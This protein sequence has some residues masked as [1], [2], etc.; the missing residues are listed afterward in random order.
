MNGMSRLE[1]S[2]N[3]TWWNGKTSYDPSDLDHV[4]AAKHLEF[5]PQ[6]QPQPGGSPIGVRGWVEIASKTDQIRWINEMSD[7]CALVGCLRVSS[8]V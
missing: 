8:A 2:E 3:V 6:P 4:Y 1:K 7:H 5:E